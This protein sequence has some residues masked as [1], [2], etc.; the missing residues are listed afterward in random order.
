MAA[1]KGNKYA[2]EW[3]L[4]NALP[5]FEDALKYAKESDE[6]LCLQDAI[7]QNGIP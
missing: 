4:E 1:E 5:R 2:Q 3:T 7:A 6:C